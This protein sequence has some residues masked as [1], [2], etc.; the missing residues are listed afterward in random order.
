MDHKLL[1]RGWFH[2]F[3]SIRQLHCWPAL[4][5]LHHSSVSKDSVKY[6]LHHT[7][8]PYSYFSI[9]LNINSSVFKYLISSPDI[10][11]LQSGLVS[12]TEIALTQAFNR[13]NILLLDI[14]I[15]HFQNACNPKGI[16]FFKKVVQP[17][18]LLP[19]LIQKHL[20][21]GCSIGQKYALGTFF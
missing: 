7:T 8:L 14:W 21:S 19:C 10:S 1:L 20:L 15:G 16:N 13:S 18:S 11:M 5:S 6:Q 3:T 12:S 4:C 9:S 17:Y 2:L